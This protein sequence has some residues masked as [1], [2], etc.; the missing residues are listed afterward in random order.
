MFW[1]YRQAVAQIING[2]RVMLSAERMRFVCYSIDPDKA[3]K[4]ESSM[5]FYSTP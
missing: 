2:G 1:T 3:S 4:W 5:E